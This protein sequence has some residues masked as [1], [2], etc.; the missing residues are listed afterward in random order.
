MIVIA[1]LIAGFWAVLIGLSI[2]CDI[3]NFL[4]KNNGDFF[5]IKK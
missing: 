5:K 1:G 2:L 4:F 3:L